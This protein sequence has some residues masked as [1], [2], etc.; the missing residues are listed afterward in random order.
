MTDTW[1]TR[2]LPVLQAIVELSDG[3]LDVVEN[4]HLADHTGLDGETVTRA[5]FALA[6]EQPPFFS[7]ID[8]SSLAGKD[9]FGVRDPTGHA[10]RTVGTWPTPQSLAEAIVAGLK[11]A[12]DTEPDPERKTVLRRTADFF[13]GVGSGVLTG[14]TTAAINGQLG[15]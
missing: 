13:A 15:G 1:T 3:G 12:A 7:Y 6:N 2:D 8:G 10:R 5:L 9:I 14:V 4:H 11:Q